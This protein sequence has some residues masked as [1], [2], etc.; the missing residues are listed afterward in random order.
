MYV[1]VLFYRDFLSE[2]KVKQAS[3]MEKVLLEEDRLKKRK[4]Q[5][6]QLWE[7]PKREKSLVSFYFDVDAIT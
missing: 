2:Q 7:D 6:P 1:S 5:Q 4:K 3:I